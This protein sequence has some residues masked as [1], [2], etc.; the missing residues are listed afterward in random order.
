MNEKGWAKI[1]V[2]KS[3]YRKN[4]LICGEIENIYIFLRIV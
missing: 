1:F 2:G 4:K 3:I